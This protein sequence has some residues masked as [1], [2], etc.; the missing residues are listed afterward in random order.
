MEEGKD[1]QQIIT[2]AFSIFESRHVA[3]KKLTL[4]TAAVDQTETVLGS[5]HVSKSVFVCL[6]ADA[7]DCLWWLNSRALKCLLTMNNFSLRVQIFIHQL[8][9]DLIQV[10]VNFEQT[11]TSCSPLLLVFYVK[12]C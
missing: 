11:Q 9:T 5:F 3:Y 8:C 2:P 4:Q 1:Q 12:L 6:S 7:Q 10:L